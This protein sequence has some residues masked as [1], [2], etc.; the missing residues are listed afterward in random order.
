MDLAISMSSTCARCTHSKNAR[1][2]HSKNAAEG[3]SV[4]VCYA[5][6]SPYFVTPSEFASVRIC[7]RATHPDGESASPTTITAADMSKVSALLPDGDKKKVH[8]RLS[9]TLRSSFREAF[10]ARAVLLVEGDTDVAVFTHA[11]HLMGIDLNSHGVVSTSVGKSVVPVAQAILTSLDIPTYVVFD[12]DH[13]QGTREP[14]EHCGRGGRDLN[15]DGKLNRAILE[16]VGAF[17][18][19]FRSRSITRHGRVSVSTWST[20]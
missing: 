8:R 12:G 1:C 2:T 18:E 19:D 3:G 10:F 5:T 20:T 7:R 15:N 4:Q 16:I 11:A 6:H 9:S 13:H 17:V 14:C